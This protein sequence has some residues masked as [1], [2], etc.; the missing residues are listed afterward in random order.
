VLALNPLGGWLLQAHLW[1]SNDPVVSELFAKVLAV[2]ILALPWGLVMLLVMPHATAAYA[3]SGRVRDLFD[4]GQA[5]RRLSRDFATWNLAAAAIV[6]GWAIGLAC[7]GLFFVGLVPG[8]FYAILV[9]AHASAAL[10]R[11][12]EDSSPG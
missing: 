12:G 6:T 7:A 8:V 3:A 1:R 4:P 9:S 2:C 11:Q 10:H 5:V